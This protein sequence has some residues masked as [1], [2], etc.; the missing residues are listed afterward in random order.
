MRNLLF[1]TALT[2]MSSAFAVEFN[3]LKPEEQKYFK[4]DSMDGKNMQERID[5]DVREINKLYGEVAMLKA[6]VQRL[7]NDLD[8]LKKQ[9]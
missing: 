8:E 5:M 2:F 3:Y 1:V 4:N 6:E 7:R 9:K